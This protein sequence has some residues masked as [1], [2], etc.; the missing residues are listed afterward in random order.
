MAIWPPASPRASPRFERLIVASAR[1]T[2]GGVDLLL[3]I[4][5]GTRSTKGVL[6]DASGS[7][8]AS[9][10][11]A[12]SMQLPRPGW[13]EVDAEG[14]WWREVCNISTTLMAQG[15]ARANLRAMCV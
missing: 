3:G 7:V 6:V 11:V 13:A 1:R 10:T 12:H 2:G 4:D 8:I 15:D 5:M 14:M 9:E